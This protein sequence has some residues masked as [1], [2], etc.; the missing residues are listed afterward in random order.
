[1]LERLKV[2]AQVFRKLSLEMP[3][4]VRTG[5]VDGKKISAWIKEFEEFVRTATKEEKSD[6]QKADLQEKQFVTIVTHFLN[7]LSEMLKNIEKNRE[8]EETSIATNT[9]F[10]RAEALIL[11]N[12]LIALKE[13]FNQTIQNKDAFQSAM[14]QFYRSFLQIGT[15]VVKIFHDLSIPKDEI[16]KIVRESMGEEIQARLHSMTESMIQDTLKT[17]HELAAKYQQDASFKA[18][19]KAGIEIPL[20]ITLREDANKRIDTLKKDEAQLYNAYRAIQ[21]Y[22]GPVREVPDEEKRLHAK[23]SALHPDEKKSIEQ[24]IQCVWRENYQDAVKQIATLPSIVRIRLSDYINQE[25]IPTLNM[26]QKARLNPDFKN[27]CV[28]KKIDAKLSAPLSQLISESMMTFH[29]NVQKDIALAGKQSKKLEHWIN[30]MDQLRQLLYQSGSR[31]YHKR[32]QVLFLLLQGKVDS[33]NVKKPFFEKY[34]RCEF[35]MSPARQRLLIS[36]DTPNISNAPGTLHARRLKES[37]HQGLESKDQA[38]L[39][40]I[41]G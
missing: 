11:K 39:P 40:K 36:L 37:K 23:L 15:S 27:A 41:K 6:E 7:A 31:E 38:P 2:E 33:M 18:G 29:E 20:I 26:M 30:V 32:M 34:K 3:D 5:E 16:A 19:L 8:I 13:Q 28:N 1:M 25:E 35:D 10:P 24:I 12:R 4:A 17:N 22:K 21:K 9:L 14:Q